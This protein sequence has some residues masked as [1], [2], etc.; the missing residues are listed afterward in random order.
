MSFIETIPYTET[1]EYVQ[2]VISY[3]MIYQQ[4]HSPD[5]SMFTEAERNFAY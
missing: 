1:R 3:R 5:A 4:S 2:A